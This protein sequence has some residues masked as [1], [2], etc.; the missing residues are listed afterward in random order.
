MQREL[1]AGLLGLAVIGLLLVVVF[2]SR[3]GHP[4]GNAEVTERSIPVAIENT[5]VTLVTVAWAL[6]ILGAIIFGFRYR[7]S[8][9][10]P[11]SN[12]LR[13]FGAVLVLMLLITVDRLSRARRWDRRIPARAPDAAA[14]TGAHR[15]RGSCS[16]DGHDDRGLAP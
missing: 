5:V 2:A 14:R 10:E 4:T 12:W 11:E 15:G 3:G 8:W 9:R 16:S 6:M 13:N 7:Q 1:K